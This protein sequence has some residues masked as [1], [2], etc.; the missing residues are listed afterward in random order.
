MKR[1]LVLLPL[2]LLLGYGATAQNQRVVN[3]PQAVLVQLSPSIHSAQA[4]RAT[5][6]QA[7][8]PIGVM[9]GHLMHSNEFVVEPAAGQTAET[10]SAKLKAQFPNAQVRVLSADRIQAMFDA[11]SRGETPPRE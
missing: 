2:F 1:L 4:D 10:L 6:R 5:L 9:V 8:A 7:T 3:T 11:A